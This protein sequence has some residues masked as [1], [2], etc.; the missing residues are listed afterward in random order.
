MN[1]SENNRAGLDPSGSVAV[2]GTGAM[3]S[4]IAQT[5]LAPARPTTAWNRTSER[6]RALG[7]HA[8][9]MGDVIDSRE[10]ARPV[11]TPHRYASSRHESIKVFTR[12]M[13]T[14]A[15]RA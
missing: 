1:M 14:T 2:L 10:Q 13:A 15:S 4:A 5:V 11:S 6:A 3:G 9:L 12:G 8:A 7:G